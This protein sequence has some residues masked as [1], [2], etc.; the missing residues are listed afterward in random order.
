MKVNVQKDLTLL[1]MKARDCVTGFEGVV[2]SISFDLYGCN[3]ALINPGLDKEGKT[4]D[5]HWFDI[6]R[7]KIISKH[8]VMRQPEFVSGTVEKGAEIKP[9]PERF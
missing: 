9:I 8:P 5:S 3:S 1:G 7:L 6:N 2:T 4:K